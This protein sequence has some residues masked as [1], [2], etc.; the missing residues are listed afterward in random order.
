[1]KRDRASQGC[2]GYREIDNKRSKRSKKL[3]P[4]ATA[5]TVAG[6]DFTVL[7]VE[8]CQHEPRLRFD[9]NHFGIWTNAPGDYGQGTGGVNGFSDERYTR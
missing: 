3:P 8:A 5:A 1:M 6:G 7:V 2:V 9:V 4:Q